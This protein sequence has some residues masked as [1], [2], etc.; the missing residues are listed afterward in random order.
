[1]RLISLIYTENNHV[2]GGKLNENSVQVIVKIMEH[3]K[4]CK[5]I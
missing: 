1:M 3:L 4:D 5:L 2:F